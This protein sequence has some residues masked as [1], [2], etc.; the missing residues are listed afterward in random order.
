MPE[1]RFE[2]DEPSNVDALLRQIAAR[3]GGG[4]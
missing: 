1:L 4:S 2:Y 3:D